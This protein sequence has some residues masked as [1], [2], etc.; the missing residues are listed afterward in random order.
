MKPVKPREIPMSSAMKAARSGNYVCMAHWFPRINEIARRRHEEKSGEP[1]YRNWTNHNPHCIGLMGET[2]FALG[3]G[4]KVNT[5]LLDYGDGHFDF[6]CH[7]VTIDVKTSRNI[8]RDWFETNNVR[9]KREPFLLL[10]QGTPIKA[11]Y[12]VLAQCDKDLRYCR[13]RGWVTTGQFI[14]H[15]QV[16]NLGHGNNFYMEARHLSSMGCL[17]RLLDGTRGVCYID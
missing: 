17:W 3:S 2:L 11:D 4:L 13:L 10:R 16:I 8:V 5:L 14:N 6:K 12:L 15:A 1:W 7:D 9:S